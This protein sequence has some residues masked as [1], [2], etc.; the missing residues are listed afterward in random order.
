MRGNP[1]RYTD[2]YGR[3]AEAIDLLK[4]VGE[5]LAA[6]GAVVA[7]E[8]VVTVAAVAV[9]GYAVY[10]AGEAIADAVCGNKD[11]TAEAKQ[12]AVAEK[13]SEGEKQQ[14]Q[15]AQNE[16]AKDG[17]NASGGV[18]TPPPP[19]NPEEQKPNKEQA[20]DES[21]KNSSEEITKQAEKESDGKNNDSQIQK[22][23]AQGDAFEKEV[24][25]KLKSK[26]NPVQSQITLETESGTRTRVDFI[27]QDIETGEIK[28]TEAKSSETAPLTRNQAKAYP[29]IKESGATVVGKG[30][31]PFVGGTQ[32]PPTQ[33]SIVRPSTL[34][35]SLILFF[36]DEKKDNQ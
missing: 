11:G 33:V 35:T 3:N 30:K 19:P 29:E 31:P 21:K 8:A 10:K 20:K 6:A 28:L 7:S 12:E 13:G 5:G 36:S 16:A 9:A 15:E 22:N 23:K 27:G 17:A 18:T 24:V 26:Q 14:K 1:L 4:I 2:P 25:E 32:I 34:A